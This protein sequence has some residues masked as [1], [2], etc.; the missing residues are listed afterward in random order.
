VN[1]SAHQGTSVE[2]EAPIGALLAAIAVFIIAGG[3]AALYIWWDL[4]DLL[5]GRFLLVPTLLAFVLIG[6]F[7][8]LLALWGRFLRRYTHTGS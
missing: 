5:A 2:E 8:G 4:D 1:D 6:A 7:V 3:A